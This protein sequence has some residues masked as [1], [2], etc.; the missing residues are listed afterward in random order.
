MRLDKPSCGT[1]PDLDTLF[2]L[3]ETDVD[4]S[5]SNSL[6]ALRGELASFATDREWLLEA[7]SLELRKKKNW[8]FTGELPNSFL[9][10]RGDDFSLRLNIWLP[11]RKNRLAA[12]FENTLG[13]Y[14]YPHDHNFDLLTVACFGPGYRTQI[15]EYDRDQTSGAPGELV[16][17]QSRGV[18][19]HAP[20]DVLLYE[21]CHD[22]HVQLPP[23]DVSVTLNVLPQLSSDAQMTQLTFLPHDQGVMKVMGRP[24]NFE[25]RQMGALK[26]LLKVAETDKAAEAVAIETIETC[27]HRHETP[28]VRRQA[29]SLLRALDRGAGLRELS[30][31]SDAE[32]G[33]QRYYEIAEAGRMN[34]G[35]FEGV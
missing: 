11:E 7:L 3:T 25:N 18:I 15:F 34:R 21:K 28:V 35:R 32:M 10:R 17:V 4:L 24:A 5:D 20:G 14:D 29:T 22:I 12:S 2:K 26:L 9:L 1:R 27:A 8:N 13:A 6:W 19:H 30:E 23:E 31:L 33:E 16:D